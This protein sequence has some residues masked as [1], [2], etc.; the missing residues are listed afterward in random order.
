[1]AFISVSVGFKPAGGEIGAG[2]GGERQPREQIPIIAAFASTDKGKII[3]WA[4]FLSG[5]WFVVREAEILA[6]RIVFDGISHQPGANNC[7]YHPKPDTQSC[8]GRVAAANKPP[9]SDDEPPNSTGTRDFGRSGLPR[10]DRDQRRI[11]RTR[12]GAHGAGRRRSSR[13]GNSRGTPA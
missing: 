8:L 1:S 6:A 12:P 3:P 9:D 2:S 7:A 13:R 11:D 10:I 4:V 5:S